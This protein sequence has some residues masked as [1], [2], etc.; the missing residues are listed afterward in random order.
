MNGFLLSVLLTLAMQK[1]AGRIGLV[2][3]P[4]ARKNH[5]GQVP[6]A[7]G[8]LFVAFAIAAVL[9][10]RQPAGFAGFLTGLTLL[11]LL[12]IVDDLIDLSAPIKLVAQIV[13]VGLMILPGNVLVWNVGAIL[14]D[15]PLLLLQWAVPATII[16]V[17]GLINAVNMMDGADGLIGSVSLAALL[18][19]ATAAVMIGLYPELLITLTLG[20]C[21]LGFLTF[22]LRHRWRS[23][24]SVFLGDA[25]S[26]MLGAIL[27]FLAIKLSQQD[28]RPSLSPVATLWIGALPIIDTASLIL[29]RLAVGQSPLASD[30]RHLHH[31]MLQAGLSVNQVVGNARHRARSFDLAAYGRRVIAALGEEPAG[32]PS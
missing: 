20:C 4:T 28:N 32:V 29:R 22:N 17:V 24:A 27:A 30:R 12:G 13:C 7:G 2:D 9:L 5:E 11:V 31:L 19:L 23:C 26:M 8:G 14:H 1:Y 25:G 21:V 16:V 18:W 10:E 3:V 6:L 15:R